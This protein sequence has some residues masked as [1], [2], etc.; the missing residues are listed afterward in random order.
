MADPTVITP[1]EDWA[2]FQINQNPDNTLT[3]RRITDTHH[4]SNA[5][6]SAAYI[7]AKALEAAC[8]TSETAKDGK[9]TRVPT[10]GHEALALVGVTLQNRHT[11]IVKYY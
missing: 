1:A 4:V 6:A 11:Y 5:F 9:I 8:V 2:F 10:P 3:L 7:D